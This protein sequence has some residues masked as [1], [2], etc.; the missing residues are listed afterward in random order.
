MATQRVKLRIFVSSPGDVAEERVVTHRVLNRLIRRFAG[1]V[2]IEAIFWEH[3]PLLSSASFQAQIPRPSETDIVVTILWARLG[4]RLPREITRPDGSTYQSGTEVEFEDAL[5]GRRLRGTPDLIVYR[6]QAEPVVSLRNE[7]EL[8]ERLR[9][10]QALDQFFERWF[11]GEDGTL[12]AAFHPFTDSG[13]F[14][15]LVELHLGKLVERWVKQHGI[16]VDDEQQ[17]AASA[18]RWD[19]SPY[20]GLDVFE[21]EQCSD[22]LWAN[23]GD[24]RRTRRTAPAGRPRTRVLARARGQWKREVVVDSGRRL[25]DV[26]RAKRD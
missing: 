12:V 16:E 18:P 21:M 19:G 17:L 5:E 15:E 9:Q 6:K 23:E 13:Q 24:R 26:A 11:H 10:K 4:T 20:R 8:L 25:A 7:E 22:L 14:E 1:I 3:E 2:E